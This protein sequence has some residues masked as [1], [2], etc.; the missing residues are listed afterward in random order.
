VNSSFT[1]YS[2]SLS[3]TNAMFEK[4]GIKLLAS[5]LENNSQIKNL[6]LSNSNLSSV[7][8]M[9]L[10]QGLKRANHLVTLSL[11]GNP[12]G[13]KGIQVI[14]ENLPSRLDFFIDNCNI[15]FIGCN[16]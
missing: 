8:A 14:A 11:D 12:I 9:I 3:L 13:D 1:L 10:A 16:A 4:G 7:D 2:S 5:F 15:T 6:F